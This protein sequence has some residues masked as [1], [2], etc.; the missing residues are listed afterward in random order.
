MEV[1]RLVRTGILVGVVGMLIHLTSAVVSPVVP[2]FILGLIYLMQIP[3]GVSPERTPPL[4]DE[5]PLPSGLS[6]GVAAVQGG[7][8]YMEDMHQ[9][10]TFNAE[11]GVANNGSA[12]P[13]TPAPNNSSVQC[14]TAD[15]IGL[16]NFFAVYD[17]HGGKLAAQYVHKHLVSRIVA[18]LDTNRANSG[19]GDESSSHEALLHKSVREGFLQAD[20]AFIRGAAKLGLSD[21][22]TAIAAL[23]Q[24]N[25]VLTVANVG[26]SR[27]ALVRKD[28]SCIALSSDHKPN[29]PDEKA[30]VCAAGGWVVH[31]GCWRV[32]GDLAVSRAF[33]DR[34]LKRYGVC[35]DPEIS[36]FVLVPADA[37]IVLASDGLW[38]VVK[39]PTCGQVLSKCA[40][41]LDGAKA[42]CNLALRRGSGDNISVLIIDVTRFTPGSLTP[43]DSFVSAAGA[44][45]NDRESE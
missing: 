8:P 4:F 34:H 25:G 17:G 5:Q 6:Y 27:C 21:G 9:V 1:A 20:E 23:L 11:N 43:L 19:V 38:D 40:S 28:G 35:A 39:E 41:A 3:G 32:A 15:A 31:Q 12:T 7:R 24:R 10:V 16:L 22:S 13:S 33:G 14:S 36:R 37:F 18:A 29:R 2:F 26:D 44:S 45:T 30:R 42:L